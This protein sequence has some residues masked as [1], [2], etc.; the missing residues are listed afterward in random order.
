MSQGHVLS[1]LHVEMYQVC[2]AITFWLEFLKV[3]VYH[4]NSDTVEELQAEI[5]AIICT[6]DGNSVSSLTCKEL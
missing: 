6:T 3:C 1:T 2:S 5:K 4:N